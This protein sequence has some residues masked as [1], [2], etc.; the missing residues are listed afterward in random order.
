ML[1]EV[2]NLI[3]ILA[4]FLLFISGIVFTKTVKFQQF[5]F[6]KMIKLSLEKESDDS[7]KPIETLMLNL[8][9]RVGV[10][11]ISGVA[12]AVYIG[13][14]GTI[15]WMWITTFIASSNT[16]LESMLGVLYKEKDKGNIYKG[17]P[18]YYI[19]KG[20]NNKFLANT[21]ALI[22]IFA[23]GVGFLTIQSNTISKGILE[24]INIRPIIIGVITSILVGLVI[25][26]GV[27][28]IA[29]VTNFL[30]PFMGI[31]YFII[32]LVI[33]FKSSNLIVDIFKD[34]FI[35]AFDLTSM[36]AGF[37]STILIG[38][39]RGIFSNEAGLGTG[40][41]AA[42]VTS[43]KEIKK[44]GYIQTF[45][46]HIDTLIIG[47]ISALVVLTT[48]Y[49]NLGII[50]ANGIEIAKYAFNYHLGAFGNITLL[51]II[52]L[53]AFASIITGYYYSESSLKFLKRNIGKKGI[54][55]FQINI[56]LFVILGSIISSTV[57]W[58]I[59][60]ILIGVMAI[61]NCY[62]LWMLRDKVKG[63]I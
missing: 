49:S 20:M 26:R 37:I 5:N 28:G 4:I 10:G 36:G 2:N 9:A 34:I 61:I 24:V 13:G 46:L 39:Q 22:I 60:D 38:I 45:G 19:E 63:H 50:D 44:Q 35:D 3:W 53:F 54:L 51:L 6:F 47:T 29:R 31:L 1:R 57:L 14:P 11:S 43:S 25:I 32:C 59:V 8:A 48:K 30:V 17:G 56:L 58:N 40:A 55:L 33:L 42:G 23:F 12:L 7:I 18:S 15:F 27:K 52:F 21:F 62:A 41:I 16:F